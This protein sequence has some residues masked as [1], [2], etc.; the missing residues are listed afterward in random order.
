MKRLLNT[1]WTMRKKLI[2]YMLILV[3]IIV[4]ALFVGIMLIG[5][6]DSAEKNLQSSLAFQMEAFEKDVSD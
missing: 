1:K 6:F 2:L 4:F 5:R 3:L